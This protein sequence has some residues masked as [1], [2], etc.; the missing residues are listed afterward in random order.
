[1]SHGLICQVCNKKLD[2]FEDQITVFIIP[3]HIIDGGHKQNY[4]ITCHTK[5]K[6]I[7]DEAIVQHK[8][9]GILWD[10]E[11]KIEVRHYSK[12]GASSH[13]DYFY[14]PPLTYEQVNEIHAHIG[15]KRTDK[16]S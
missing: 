2:V 3:M 4:E 14:S 15:R 5:C 13:S 16:L 12:P 1:M 8:I 11:N 7:V 6:K 9:N 10:E